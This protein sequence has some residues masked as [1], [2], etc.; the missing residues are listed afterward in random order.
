MS[1]RFFAYALFGVPI[2]TTCSLG[3]WQ[4]SRLQWKQSLIDQRLKTLEEAP[5]PFSHDLF[6][7]LF[8]IISQSEVFAR[9]RVLQEIPV[10]WPFHS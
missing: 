1:R 4:L 7:K 2:A 8:V 9:G 10:D 6:A 5:I 3:I